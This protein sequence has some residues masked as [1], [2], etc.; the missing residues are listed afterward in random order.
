MIQ[1]LKQLSYLAGWQLRAMMGRRTPLQSVIF[2]LDQCNLRCKHCS[3]YAIS[4]PRIKTM[5]EIRE[6]LE[7]CYKMGSR[8]VDFEGGELYLW[9]DHTEDGRTLD[10]NDVIDMAHEIGFWNVTITTNAQLPFVGTHADQVWVSMDGVGEWHDQIRGKGAFERLAKHIG[11][12]GAQ[13]KKVMGRKAPLCVNM[14]VNCL[15]YKNLE[16]ALEFVRSNPNIDQISVNFHTPFA[17]TEELFLDPD[18]R[19]ALIDKLI[20][21]KQKGYPIM[22]SYSGLKAMKMVNG[23]TIC[24]DEHCWITNFIFS[25]GSRSPKCMG[26]THHVCD[27]CGFSMGGEMYAVRHFKPD[28]LF[29]GLKLRM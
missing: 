27:R 10:I 16:G 5:Q 20:K 23:K 25:D 24:T 15:N 2:I 19:N 29:S 9:K 18:I 1:A 11:E 13:Q 22:N 12:Y 7:D 3:V 8:F 4:K 28:T 14:V 21:Y 17:E 6:E 26:Y